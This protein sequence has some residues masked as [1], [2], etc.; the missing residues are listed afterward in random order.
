MLWSKA[1]FFKK[2]FNQRGPFANFWKRKKVKFL[3][4]CWVRF[5]V[6]WWWWVRR[7]ST[8]PPQTQGPRHLARGCGSSLMGLVLWC[9]S[10]LRSRVLTGNSFL[11]NDSSFPTWCSGRLD[12]LVSAMDVCCF[13]LS[14]PIQ[15]CGPD[16][17]FCDLHRRLWARVSAGE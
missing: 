9:Q 13:N 16:S 8:Y 12:S 7:A 3:L 14:V 2:C 5:L 11:K 10:C 6:L 4:F 17:A 15:I 1:L